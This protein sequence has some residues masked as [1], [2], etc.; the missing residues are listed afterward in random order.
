MVDQ[1]LDI[2]DETVTVRQSTKR[3]GLLGSAV[4]GKEVTDY[5]DLRAVVQA[6]APEWLEGQADEKSAVVLV[7]ESSPFM[8]RLVRQELEM[9]GHRV[10]EAGDT[11]EVL[12]RVEGGGVGMILAGANLPPEGFAGLRDAI[13]QQPRLANIPVVE[14]P[15]PSGG[16]EAMLAS[17][18][19]LAAAVADRESMVPAES[20]EGLA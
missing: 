1:I 18:G 8:R 6:A 2:A 14:L 7:A 17:I 12:S 3:H 4:V 16:R 9:A 20:A 10:V 19:Q 15:S 11:L 13:R 5:L